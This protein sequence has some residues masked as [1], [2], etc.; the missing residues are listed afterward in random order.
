MTVRV[1]AWGHPKL[2]DVNFK[3]AR[4]DAETQAMVK[5]YP[6]LDVQRIEPV[7][8]DAIRKYLEQLR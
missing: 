3:A 6:M 5:D 8:S 4:F 1:R 7:P 2:P